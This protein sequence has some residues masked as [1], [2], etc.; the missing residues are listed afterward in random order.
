M[1]RRSVAPRPRAAS[2][3]SIS[4]VRSTSARTRRATFIQRVNAS[5]ATS[6]VS[7]GPQIA[8]ITMIRK[9]VGTA[10]R[11]SVTRM[12]TASTLPPK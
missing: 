7:E 9:K 3:K 8:T 2:T 10:M 11:P 4:L 1:S 5:D 12:M 6:T